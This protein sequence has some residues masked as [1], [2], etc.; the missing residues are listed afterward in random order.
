MRL[1]AN[2]VNGVSTSKLLTR[3]TNQTLED[4][5]IETLGVQELHVKK[6]N[7][8]EVDKAAKMSQ[9]NIIK[10]IVTTT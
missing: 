3:N 8:V 2:E 4:I 10:G 9:K 7:G 1:K 5:F 6:I